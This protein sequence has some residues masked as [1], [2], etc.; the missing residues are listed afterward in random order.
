MTFENEQK[1]DKS[2]IS[3]FDKCRSGQDGEVQ[4]DEI[5]G[6]LYRTRTSARCTTRQ[7]VV[8]SIY[9][10]DI[11]RL[12]HETPKTGHQ[13]QRR[14]KLRV[15]GEFYWPGIYRAINRYIKSCDTCQERSNRTF[16]TNEEV[17][18]LFP[19]S[20][21]K[22]WMTWKGPYVVVSQ[23]SDRNYR[24]DVNGKSRVYHVNMLD[25][26]EGRDTDKMKDI[27][28]ISNHTTREIPRPTSDSNR[29]FDTND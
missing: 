22:R 3:C 19:I 25:K 11:I 4:F 20:K 1:N 26:C 27:Q 12:G 18:V 17:M 15:T 16:E 2:L 23:F 28:P 29:I 6:L 8:P 21:D 13:G 14:T 7:L 24:I 9:R 10:E 5:N